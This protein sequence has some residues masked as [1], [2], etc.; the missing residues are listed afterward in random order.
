MTP[1]PRLAALFLRSRGAPPALA[2]LAAIAALGAPL[3]GWWSGAETAPFLLAMVP[4][5]PAVV[6][7]AATRSP[8]G[9]AERTASRSL[10]WLRFGQVALL[11]AGGALALLA[12][13]AAMRDGAGWVLL[14]NGAGLAGLALLGARLLG[15]G[16]AWAPPLAYLAIVHVAWMANE[17]RGPWGHW[18]LTDA[19]TSRGTAVALLA[20]LGGAA[21]VVAS[22]ARTTVG[23][24]AD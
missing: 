11:L 18:V 1:T 22:G 7:G 8:F 19:P 4:L 24:A 9:E 10:P 15:A 6:L 2:E 3:L 14:R 13:G 20:L 17:G 16:L 12:I 21:L 23:E 5:A